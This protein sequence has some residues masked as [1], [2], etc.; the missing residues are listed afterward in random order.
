MKI[1]MLSSTFPYPPTR[2][3]TQVRTFHLMKYLTQRH[4]VILVTHRSPDVTEEEVEGLRGC[5]QD[6]AI[7]ARPAFSSMD[8]A[9]SK[10]KRFANFLREGTPPNVLSSYSLKMQN[11]VDRYVESAIA[12]GEAGDLVITCEHSVNEIYVRPEWESEIATVVNIHSSLYGTCRQLLET[13]TSEKPLRDRLQLPLLQRYEQRYCSKFS[14]I[15]V[16]TEEDQKQILDLKPRAKIAAIANGVD[17]TRFPLRQFDPGRHQLVF[18]GAMD[19]LPNIDAARFL[20]LEVFPLVRLRYP[21]AT[22][23]LVGSRPVPEVQ[24]LANQPGVTVTG[25][26]PSIAEYLHQ[27]T[28]CVIPMRTGYG[29]K[30]KTLEAMAAGTPVLASDR[31]L[32]GLTVEGPNVPLRA[33]RANEVNEYVAAIGRLFEDRRLRDQLSVNARRFVEQDYTWEVAG[34]RYETLLRELSTS[35]S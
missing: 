13:N 14:G 16:T 34:D 10:V 6:V 17:L 33:L 3:G 18:S 35:K 30:N 15:V 2:G 1:L 31:G 26:V 28:V 4:H 32:E 25:Q 11:W 24:E 8:G 20:A 23:A 21:D 9:F 19:N 5:V 7:F 29:I 27:A 12:K 22:L